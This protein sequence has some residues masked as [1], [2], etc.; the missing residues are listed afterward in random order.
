MSE[1][2]HFCTVPWLI[3][4]AAMSRRKFY[5]L[6]IAVVTVCILLTAAH[7]IY[8]ANA[9]EHSSIITFIGGEMW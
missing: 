9:Y 1:L 8:A 5:I 7:V 4:E 2:L 6:L 3:C